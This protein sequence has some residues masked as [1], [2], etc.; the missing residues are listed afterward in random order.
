MKKRVLAMLACLMLAVD[1]TGCGSLAR[2]ATDKADELKE[3]IAASSDEE[4][5]SDEEDQEVT[6][7]EVTETASEASE[8]AVEEGLRHDYTLPYAYDA[9]SLFTVDDKGNKTGEISLT[10]VTDALKKVNDSIEDVTGYMVKAVSGD[11][12]FVFYNPYDDSD[13]V[14]YAVNAKTG[15]VSSVLETKYSVDYVDIYEGKAYVGVK[16][17]KTS[18]D[19]N[20]GFTEYVVSET[21]DGSDFDV[22]ENTYSNLES[23]YAQYSF[24]PTHENIGYDPFDYNHCFSLKR[25]MD[26][27]GFVVAHLTGENVKYYTIDPDGNES[28]ID[29]LNTGSSVTILGYNKKRM[30]YELTSEDGREKEYY[31]YDF[32]KKAS[33]PID[34][35]NVGYMELNDDGCYFITESKDFGSNARDVYAYDFNSGDLTKI[36]SK[37]HLPLSERN[38]AFA[39]IFG[40]NLF[41]QNTDDSELKWFRK[42]LSSGSDDGQ[43]T[44]CTIKEIRAYNYGKIDYD[45]TAKK[46]P[47]CGIDVYKG[48]NEA[49]ILDGRYS[50]HADEINTFFEDDLKET[51]DRSDS[52]DISDDSSC[53]DHKEYPEQYCTTVES[54]V[55]DVNILKD[56]YLTVE[57]GSYW[58]GGGAHGMPDKNQYI[59]DLQTGKQMEV[60]D[61]YKGTE[62]DFK[63]LVAEKT[64]EDYI[65]SNGYKYFAENAD[66]AYN[67]AY[68]YARI[69]S[70]VFLEEDRVI[71]SFAPYDM[72]P[73]ASGF[74]DIELPIEEFELE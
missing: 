17:Y 28:A 27:C 21:G 50:D 3:R 40:E 32:E 69:D 29:D 10:A 70:Y 73:F 45:S 63:K 74:I 4:R 43:A 5:E 42:D 60:K 59:F 58:Y 14:L 49:F 51:M 13:S 37:K 25:V 24:V 65:K 56:R 44:D 66:E 9:E 46:C 64:K 26:H 53:E 52:E 12:V 71:Y 1:I 22:E 33:T 36:F 8:E 23:Y 11:I 35:E 54:Y 47:Y 6:E 48:Y 20:M 67:T 34:I 72:G 2:L 18:E 19:D 31:L 57:Y 41:Y 38:A 16:K 55:T 61:F 62:E 7:D 68:E 30:V 15:E 39:C